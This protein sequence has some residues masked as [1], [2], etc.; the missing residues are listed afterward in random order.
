MINLSVVLFAALGFLGVGM[1]MCIVR[2]VIGPTPFDRV[3]AFDGAVL[4]ILG[5]LLLISILEDSAAYMDVIL[6]VGLLGFI[7][8][9][10]FAVYLEDALVD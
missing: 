3:L 5:G 10:S 4:H 7:G 9:I 1:C 6:V 8:T 2:A